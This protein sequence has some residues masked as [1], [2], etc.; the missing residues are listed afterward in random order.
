MRFLHRR[1][2]GDPPTTLLNPKEEEEEEEEEDVVKMGEVATTTPPTALPAPI[3]VRETTLG[4]I[5][6]MIETGEE[7]AG[8]EGPLAETEIIRIPL[9][10]P[11]TP[12]QTPPRTRVHLAEE[13]EEELQHLCLQGPSLNLLL[14]PEVVDLM[15]HPLHHRY[16]F[17]PPLL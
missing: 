17:L 5:M 7:T 15:Q 11:R 8:E 12:R 4:D 13:E 6:T 10:P 3:I 1:N 9:T 14:L 16:H 2:S